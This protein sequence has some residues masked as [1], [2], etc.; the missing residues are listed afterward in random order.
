MKGTST[1]KGKGKH[2]E[3]LS[4]TGKTRRFRKRSRKG[5]RN[6]QRLRSYRKQLNFNFKI[7]DF[8]LIKTGNFH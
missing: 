4:G 8:S 1:D 2:I 5:P 3:G 7:D 6:F